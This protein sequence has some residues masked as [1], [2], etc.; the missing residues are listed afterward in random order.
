MPLCIVLC[1]GNLRIWLS[2]VVFQSFFYSV[3]FESLDAT[4]VTFDNSTKFVFFVRAAFS[5][6]LVLCYVNMSSKYYFFFRYIIGVSLLTHF[7]C[8]MTATERQSNCVTNFCIRFYFYNW[9][10]FSPF[11]TYSIKQLSYSHLKVIFHFT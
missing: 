8:F 6:V 9:A 7:I 5:T 10:I 3:L 11:Y 4:V 2:D 1:T